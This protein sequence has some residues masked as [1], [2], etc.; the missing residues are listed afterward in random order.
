MK[1]MGQR[2][3]QKRIELGLTQEEL[4]KKIGVKKS[5][6]SKIEKGEVKTI[7]RDYIAKMIQLF[8]C[9][10]SWLMD[11]SDVDSV[12]L[13]YSAPGKEPIKA[14]VNLEPPVI[15]PASLRA[16]L[17]QAAVDVLPENLQTAIDILKSLGR[18]EE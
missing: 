7:D 10:P 4:G 3:R 16:K 17:Y 9:D 2:I 12:E 15:G 8:H 11:L 18:R 6:I 13:T 14:I 1:V 5:T